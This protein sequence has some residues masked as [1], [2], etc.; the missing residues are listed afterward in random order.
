MSRG[1][2]ASCTDIFVEGCGPVVRDMDA[3]DLVAANSLISLASRIAKRHPFVF[4]PDFVEDFVAGAATADMMSR[5]HIQSG[6]DF[7]NLTAGTLKMKGR[8]SQGRDGS[9]D[10]NMANREWRKRHELVSLQSAVIYDL[11]VDLHNC[12]AL[13]AMV[14]HAV[15]ENQYVAGEDV[16]A[17]VLGSY[18]KLGGAIHVPRAAHCRDPLGAYVRRGLGA[19]IDAAVSRLASAACLT[20]I[21]GGVSAPKKYSEIED[22]LYGILDGREGG[23]S[24]QSLASAALQ[25][26]PLLRWIPDTGLL[27]ACL[28]RMEGEG[29][30]VCRGSGRGHPAYGQ[31]VFA[32]SRYD[33]LVERARRDAGRARIKFFGRR[34]TPDRFVGELRLLDPGDLDDLDDQVTRMAGLVMSDAAMPQSPRDPTG[35]FDFAVDLSGYT[36]S[37]KQEDLMRR[38]DFEASSTMFHCKVMI[39]SPVT[40]SA[41]A[42]LRIAVPPGEQGVVFTCMDV[43]GRVAA[44]AKADRTVQVVD[45]Q[46][47]REWCAATPTMPCRKN[48]VA[49]VMYGDRE[50]RAAM[51]RSLNYESGLATVELAP[52]R[53]EA[54]LPIGCLKEVGPDAPAAGGEFG[55]VSES[56]FG[57]VCALAEVAPGTFE[58]GIRECA[59]PVHRTRGA[60]HAAAPESPCPAGPGRARPRARN[61]YV[62]FDGGTCEVGAGGSGHALVC[63]CLHS[64]NSEYRTTLCRHLVAAVAA[65]AA[66][67][68]DP[69]AT[70]GHLEKSLAR[71]REDNVGRA[72]SALGD[73]LGDGDR[74]LLED[75]LL[76]RADAA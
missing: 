53:A 48:S 76:A 54:T 18:E 15:F 46:G 25:E 36:F 39:N 70:I 17:A 61:R 35:V 42:R 26:L 14:A 16:E 40:E 63:T 29:R 33:L 74:G 50:G 38:L 44:S 5:Y 23:A 65:V 43:P 58:D 60:A 66:R 51:I 31:Q 27:R 59:A 19:K 57:L 20:S 12:N 52:E 9:R 10:K 22:V 55:S 64:I 68:P 72:A 30:V 28:A 37:P 73:I 7:A 32:R 1:Q 34:T 21:N 75:Y 2:G 4:L 56:F 67:D 41:L 11:L 62:A 69:A 6:P 71:L 13:T 47:I 49:L 8:R 45:E 3:G 24:Y